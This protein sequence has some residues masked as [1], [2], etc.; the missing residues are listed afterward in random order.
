MDVEVR[1]SPIGGL[2]VFATRDFEPGERIR[3][4]GIVREITPDAPLREDLGERTDHLAYPDGKVVLVGFPD[5]H[6]NHS[7]DPNAYE[8][9]DGKEVYAVARRPIR[10]DEEITFDYNINTAG[11]TSWPCNCGAARCRGRSVG[12]FFSLP[13]EIQLEYLPLLADWF[14]RRYA[15]EI[16][17]TRQGR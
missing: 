1:P 13:Q 7:C 15:N 10:A 6:V 11:G 12:D 3:R 9:Y 14:V 5:R 16:A 8:F 2:G 17:S 4:M